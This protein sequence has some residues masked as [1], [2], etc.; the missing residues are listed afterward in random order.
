MYTRG[1]LRIE[2]RDKFFRIKESTGRSGNGHN[3]GRDKRGPLLAFGGEGTRWARGR[4]LKNCRRRWWWSGG[5]TL[6]DIGNPTLSAEEGRRRDPPWLGQ[7]GWRPW[8]PLG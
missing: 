8:S 7:W 2:L 4:L 5:Y 6:E 1:S 3:N